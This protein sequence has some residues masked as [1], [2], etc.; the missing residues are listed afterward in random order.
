MKLPR[1]KRFSKKA[2]F[3]PESSDGDAGYGFRMMVGA[4]QILY[5]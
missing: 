5:G 3:L 2:R 4:T 1:L